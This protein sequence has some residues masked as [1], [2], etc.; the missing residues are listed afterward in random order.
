MGMTVKTDASNDGPSCSLVLNNCV[1]WILL[2]LLQVE[3]RVETMVKF[4][5]FQTTVINME[6]LGNNVFRSLEPVKPFVA[7]NKVIIPEGTQCVVTGDQDIF[8]HWDFSVSIWHIMKENLFRW[9]QKVSNLFMPWVFLVCTTNVFNSYRK[10]WFIIFFQMF[11]YIY[12]CFFNV[13][14]IFCY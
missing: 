6:C 7:S 3:K 8:I 1:K 11:M 14:L 9:S 12:W 13:M 10:I 2:L 4:T 5:E